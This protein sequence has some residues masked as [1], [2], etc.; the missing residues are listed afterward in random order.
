MKI[1]YGGIDHESFENL[2]C[3]ERVIGNAKY[4]C[5][6]LFGRGIFLLLAHVHCFFLFSGIDGS[7]KKMNKDLNSEALYSLLA[8]DYMNDT[9]NLSKCI[10]E[11]QRI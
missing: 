4:F 7:D 1:F 2:F 10:K 5:I 9:K 8:H 11:Y 3:I 6:L